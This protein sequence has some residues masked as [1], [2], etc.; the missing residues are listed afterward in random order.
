MDY[1]GG[2]LLFAIGFLAA[3]LAAKGWRLNRSSKFTMEGMLSKG[4]VRLDLLGRNNRAAG[5]DSDTS[6]GA[7]DSD[8][9]MGVVTSTERQSDDPPGAGGR[10][11][12]LRSRKRK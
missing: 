4:A 7:L 11:V 2:A 5:D 6:E 10:R 9:D 12:K 3:F 1:F 8:E